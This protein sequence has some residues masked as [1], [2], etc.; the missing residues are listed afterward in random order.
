MDLRDNLIFGTIFLFSIHNTIQK[1]VL[2][3]MKKLF[4]IGKNLMTIAV[5]LIREFIPDLGSRIQ[6]KTVH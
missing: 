2:K 1:K 6:Q 3:G 5:L 4:P